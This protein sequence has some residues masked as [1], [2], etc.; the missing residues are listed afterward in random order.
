MT[1]A[2]WADVFREA[3]SG[4]DAAAAAVASSCIPAPAATAEV[5]SVSGLLLR[6]RG[7]EQMGGMS[8]SDLAPFRA[9]IL[10]A[11]P[12]SREQLLVVMTPASSSSPVSLSATV[13]ASL[14]SLAAE[15]KVQEVGGIWKR[16][17][18]D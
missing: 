4:G 9:A 16:T 15:G 14:A 7:E 5:L 8:A 2:D 3:V 13:Q 1:A 6:G 18:F 12:K 10:K 11:L 17:E